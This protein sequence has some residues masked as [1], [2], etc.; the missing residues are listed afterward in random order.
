MNTKEHNN[1]K[2]QEKLDNIINRAIC[3]FND[4]ESY[5]LKNDLSERCI[6]SRFAMHITDSLKDTEFSDY[7][8]DV[9]YNRGLDAQERA[10]KRIC[11]KRI[12][13]D[14]IVHKRGY[15][16]YYGFDNLICVEIKK[17]TDR[18]GYGD[19]ES[20]LK[21][22]VNPEYGFC[23]K[24]GYMII[25]NM[26]KECLRLEIINKYTQKTV[27]EVCDSKKR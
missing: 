22:M 25:A 13:V 15:H 18:R 16:C 9:E 7:I 20:R 3:T 11:N 23:Y 21:N 1:A 27:G 5:L 8:V 14:L 6:C 10:I 26:R 2:I 24:V 17:S 12:I 4:K 19:D